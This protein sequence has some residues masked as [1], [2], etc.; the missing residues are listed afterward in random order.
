MRHLDRF[1]EEVDSGCVRIIWTEEKW[2]CGREMRSVL[3]RNCWQW[4]M[5]EFDGTGI[6][7][8]GWIHQAGFGECPALKE[9]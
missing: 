5:G 9:G 1:G 2:D 3:F 8:Q 4:G 7:G 6:R